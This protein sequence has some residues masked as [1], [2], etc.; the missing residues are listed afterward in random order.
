MRRFSDSNWWRL[1]LDTPKCSTLPAARSA[2]EGFGDLV[3]VHQRV[4]PVDQ[5]QVEPVGMQLAQRFL[6][7][8]DDVRGAGVVMLDAVRRALRRDQLDAAFADQFDPVAQRRLAPQRFAE[9]ALDAVAAVDV[10]MVEAGH[11]E[12]D[13]LLDEADALLDRHA[14]LRHAPH[15]GDD[16]RQVQS[17]GT[18]GN[19]RAVQVGRQDAS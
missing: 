13:A 10:G 3:E 12:R 1:K 9:Q 8:G 4:G 15:A 17:T 14:P 18:G 11:A 2:G 6:G 7:R 19:A 16:A 5:Q